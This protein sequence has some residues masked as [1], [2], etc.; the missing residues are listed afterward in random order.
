MQLGVERVAVARWEDVELR[1]SIAAGHGQTISVR[2]EALHR[3]LEAR[4]DSLSSLSRA[5]YMNLQA[6][7]STSVDLIDPVRIRPGES[8]GELIG[9][10]RDR[11]LRDSRFRARL[12]A[13][14]PSDRG[15]ADGGGRD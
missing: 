15:G 13:L 12:E 9:R 1:R 2:S 7:A 11:L 10:V 5:A 4:L 8:A 3:I 6:M 14:V